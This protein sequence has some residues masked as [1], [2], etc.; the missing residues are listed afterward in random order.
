[1]F[2]L[3]V[4]LTVHALPSSLWP[5]ADAGFPC[6]QLYETPAL[7]D[8]GLRVVIVHGDSDARCIS[9]AWPTPVLILCTA[10]TRQCR[11]ACT[12]MS[13]GRRPPL[14]CCQGRMAPCLPAKQR[15]ALWQRQVC[16]MR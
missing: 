8:G 6:W 1:M 11:R 9:L 13:G 7:D 12:T 14:L 15:G 5:G 2:W 4:P 3:L 10:Q 16:G